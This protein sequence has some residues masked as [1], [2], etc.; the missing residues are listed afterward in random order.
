MLI[1]HFY[2]RGI[3][4]KD[5]HHKKRMDIL[6]KT[7]EEMNYLE[8]LVKIFVIP[9]K[10]NQ[11]I[12][13]NIFNIARF[14]R[15]DIAMDTNSELTGSYTKNPFW[16]QQFD[17]RQIRTLRCGQSNVDFAVIDNCRLYVTIIKAMNFQDDI[18]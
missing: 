13:G 14:R 10:Q 5:D 7:P 2:T 15:I 8:T 17:L 16:Y 11:F 4:L 6:A 3:A 9:A 18:H 1:V 12:Q